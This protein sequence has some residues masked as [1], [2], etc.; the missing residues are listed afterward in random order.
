MKKII[1]VVATIALAGM[2]VSC[3][4][5]APVEQIPLTPKTQAVETKTPEVPMVPNALP[6]NVAATGTVISDGL[7]IN[8][9]G[10]TV[11]TASGVNINYNGDSLNITSSGTSVNSTGMTITNGEDGTYI[12]TNGNTIDTT[13]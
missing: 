1:P 11:D 4:A 8:S 9:S 7:Y 5:K 2:L 13:A 6:T 12:N 3:G 10:V